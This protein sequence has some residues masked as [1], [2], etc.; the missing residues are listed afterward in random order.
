MIDY[1]KNSA[2][3]VVVLLVILFL[4][5]FFF[6]FVKLFQ[7]YFINHKQV[8]SGRHAFLMLNTLI[9]DLTTD[10]DYLSMFC[11]LKNNPI[12]MTIDRDHYVINQ[13]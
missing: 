10:L 2:T 4:F 3:L 8:V 12:C 1:V 9:F 6:I 13:L 7:S 11:V 5:L